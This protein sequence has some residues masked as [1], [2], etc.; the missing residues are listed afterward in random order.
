MLKT[1][2]LMAVV[3][4]LHGGEPNPQTAATPQQEQQSAPSTLEDVIVDGRRLREAVDDFVDE[5]VAPPVNYGPARWHRRV[6]VGAVNFRREVAQALVDQVSSVAIQAGLEVGEPGC[7]PNILIM[8][9]DDGSALARAMVASNPR[10]FR[11]GYAG[12][13]LGSVALER[14]RSTEDAVRWWH[15]SVPMTIDHNLIAVRL[16]GQQAPLVPQDGS[17]LTTRIRNDLAGVFIV[18]DINRAAGLS[19]QQIGDY[20]GMVA[21]AQVDPDADTSTYDTVLNLFEAPPQSQPALTE[22][23]LSYLQALYGAE[24][25]QRAVNQQSGEVSN[26]MFRDRQRAQPDD[27]EP[28]VEEPNPGP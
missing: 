10:I 28:P 14:F 23:D 15:V 19:F 9:T 16:P 1:L 8:G 11:P 21:F 24:L 27:E 20:I 12:A 4:S 7:S 2:A 22:W 25:N 18:L 13:T 6:C 3:S 17:R 5:I 26:S